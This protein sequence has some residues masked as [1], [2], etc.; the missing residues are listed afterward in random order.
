MLNM[1]HVSSRIRNWFEATSLLVFLVFSHD[2]RQCFFFNTNN[3]KFFRK[4]SIVQFAE[5]WFVMISSN[6]FCFVFFL[7]PTKEDSFVRI[8]LFNSLRTGLSRHQKMTA[9]LLLFCFVFLFFEA[10]MTSCKNQELHRG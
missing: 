4:N 2:Q 3:R 5:G 6:V 9:L 1:Y 8:A 10:V 7:T